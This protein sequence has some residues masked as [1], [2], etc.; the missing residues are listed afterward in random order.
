MLKLL[1]IIFFVV[2]LFPILIITGMV[3]ATILF[4]LAKPLMLGAGILAIVYVGFYMMSKRSGMVWDS[5]R[6]RMIVS[7]EML[8]EMREKHGLV[9]NED[10]QIVGRVEDVDGALFSAIEKGLR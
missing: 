7:D 6:Q 8:A 3:S 5:E 4:A 10:A 2:V 9:M 1:A